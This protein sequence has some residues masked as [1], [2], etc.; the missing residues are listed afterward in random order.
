MRTKMPR[1]RSLIMGL[2]IAV[3]PAIAFAQSGSM[4]GMTTKSMNMKGATAP[5]TQAYID[6]MTKMQE[7]MKSMRPTNDASRDFV[8]MM[9]PHHQAAVDMAVAYQVR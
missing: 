4:Q 3:L 5:A 7:Q 8:V 9:K 6:A 2:A 1:V